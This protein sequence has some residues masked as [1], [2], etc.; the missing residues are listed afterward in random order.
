M[1]A[2]LRSATRASAL[3]EHFSCG[4][5]P[6]PRASV[7]GRPIRQGHLQVN[8]RI[9]KQS[10]SSR[11]LRWVFLVQT[12]EKGPDVRWRLQPPP[13]SAQPALLARGADA[14]PKGL[15]EVKLTQHLLLGVGEIDR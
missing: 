2:R 15:R 10:E 6:L 13:I 14:R 4:P 3:R 5:R 12:L 7:P 9:G 1:F 8:L 11:L